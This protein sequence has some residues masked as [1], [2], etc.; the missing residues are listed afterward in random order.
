[1][2]A[3]REQLRIL[4]NNI[5]LLTKLRDDNQ[6]MFENGFAEKL[7]VNRAAVQ[8]ANVETQR[9]KAL[10]SISNGYLGLKL[11]MGMPIRDSL[12]LTDSVTYETIKDGVLENTA[13]NYTNRKEYVRW[14]TEAKREETRANRLAKSVEM[15]KKGVKTPG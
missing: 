1:M 10:N 2:A 7:D 4:D 3:G 13:Y 12:V 15:L 8:I 5:A 9:T 6:K 14:I 11:L